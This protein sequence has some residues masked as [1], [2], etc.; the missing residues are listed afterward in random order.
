MAYDA[1]WLA[2]KFLEQQ[3]AKFYRDNNTLGLLE[4]RRYVIQPKYDGCLCIMNKEVPLSRQGTIVMS[5]AHIH[6][7]LSERFPDWVFF[8]EAWK[9]DTEFKD[10]S[11]EFR[12]RS[13]QPSLSY[14]VFDA[15]PYEDYCL[16]FCNIPYTIRYDT[17]QDMLRDAED[18]ILVVAAYDLVDHDPEVMAKE[19]ADNVGFD[20]GIIRDLHSPWT[21]GPSKNGAA[22]KVKPHQSLDLEV[23][24]AFEGQGILAGRA[25]GILV[26]YKQEVTAVGTGF[27]FQEREDIAAN[28]DRYIGQIAEVA[29]MDVTPKGKLR[30]PRFKGW[31]HD[32]ATSD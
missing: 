27:S 20:G 18:D 23:V 5:M 22:V 12:R 8:G 25:G 29:F 7:R 14:V 26:K 4:E 3:G 10:I 21:N 2:P 11:G 32:K 28:P 30:E 24:G 9:P 31:R 15:V 6:K 19:W 1:K 13:M 16:G 17:L